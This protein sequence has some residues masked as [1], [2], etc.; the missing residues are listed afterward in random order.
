[1]VQTQ[2]R[3]TNKCASS[4]LRCASFCFFSLS[5][6]RCVKTVKRRK[7]G[8]LLVRMV[9]SFF[10]LF[11]VI[12]LFPSFFSFPSAHSS[13]ADDHALSSLSV[14]LLFFLS[15]ASL[16]LFLALTPPSLYL[17]LLCLKPLSPTS[18]SQQYSFQEPLPITL[19]TSN[20]TSRLCPPSSS[21]CHS[22]P[23]LDPVISSYHTLASSPHPLPPHTFDTMA[24][25]DDDDTKAAILDCHV[26][27]VGA[28]IGGLM[29]G[30]LLERAD[31]KY[32]ILEKHPFHNPL[33][34]PSSPLQRCYVS[35]SPFDIIC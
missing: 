3:L 12:E 9:P 4:D 28:G 27:I 16:S 21:F 23:A 2:T 30:I 19:F 32:T 25:L 26:C 8:Q 10:S 6:L 31:I 5:S 13:F 29:M 7:E 33:G 34:N 17:F 18:L 11:F 1:M 15:L 20:L 24:S 14:F 35:R 22:Q